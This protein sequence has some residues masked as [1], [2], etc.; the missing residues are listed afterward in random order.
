MGIVYP[1]IFQVMNYAVF[2][3]RCSMLDVRETPSN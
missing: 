1:L 3:A 2:D